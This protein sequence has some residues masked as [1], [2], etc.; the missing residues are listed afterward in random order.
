M[1]APAPTLPMTRKAFCTRLLGG[2][3][4][5]V[6]QGCGGGGSSYSGAPPGPGPGAAGCTDTIAG[7]HGH[8]LTIASAD[9]D[10]AADKVYN[11]QGT[12]THNHTVTLTVANLRALKAGTTV[13]A[14]SSMTLA[15]DHAVSIL[16]T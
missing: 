8:T 9:L 4:V 13:V 16:C 7:N 3:V 2:S 15:H 6:I 5:L 12:A 1:H 14:M 10:S 11:I